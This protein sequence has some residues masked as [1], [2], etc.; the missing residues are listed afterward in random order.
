MLF[1]DKKLKVFSLISF[2]IIILINVAATAE[3]QALTL[4]YKGFSSPVGMGFDS[5]G[6]LYIADWGVGTMPAACVE[7][8]EELLV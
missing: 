6:N 3:G 4:L 5:K 8:V 7:D 1:I 2:V